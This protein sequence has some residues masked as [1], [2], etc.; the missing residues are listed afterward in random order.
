MKFARKTYIAQLNRLKDIDLIKVITG[1]RRS[2][3]STLLR[4]FA[5]QLQ[6]QGVAQDQIIQIDFDNKANESLLNKDNLFEYVSG[7]VKGDKRYYVFLDE[8]QMVKDFN[9]TL[10]SIKQLGTTD[11]FITGS[12][13]H[14]LSSEIGTLLTGRHIDLHL[15]PLSFAEF[16]EV[17]RFEYS[18][19]DSFA[20]YLQYGG[21]PGIYE[22]LSVDGKLVHEYL[23]TL[24]SDIITKDIVVRKKIQN[25]DAFTKLTTFLGNSAGS[26]I[27][28]KN[29]A[30]IFADERLTVSHN[31][32]LAYI[33]YLNECFLYSKCLRYNI[34]GKETLRTHY[35]EYA[36]DNALLKEAGTGS[37]IGHQL[38]NLVYNELRTRGFEVFTGKLYNGE[39]DF[40]AV[41]DHEPLYVQVCYLLADESIVER[42]FSAFRPIRDAYPKIVLSMDTFDFRRDGIMHYNL[43]DWLLNKPQAE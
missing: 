33:D 10:N 9:L 23:K 20:R 27:S 35:K 6:E 12:N 2:G 26:P 13:S 18:K 25:L 14:L 43:I 24:V 36:V 19:E 3:K 4:L 42:E 15:W 40:V 32:I 41:K 30:N 31:T 21:F 34:T 39:V 7:R 17:D 29:I 16:Y 8:I 38:E 22:L 5:E 28:S 11:I 37:N 1:V